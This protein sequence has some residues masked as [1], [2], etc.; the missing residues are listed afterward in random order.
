M[1][2]SADVDSGMT[3]SAPEQVA[4]DDH[5]HQRDGARKHLDG[6]TVGRLS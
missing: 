4:D 1:P 3:R 2:L 6:T 5:D